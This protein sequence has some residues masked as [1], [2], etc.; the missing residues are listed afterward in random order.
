MESKRTPRL[1]PRARPRGFAVGVCAA[2]AA[3]G[4][5]ASE[6]VARRLRNDAVLFFGCAAGERRVARVDPV[7]GIPRG[8]SLGKI[9]GVEC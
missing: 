2:A 4:D 6:K 8:V 1:D 9:R 5:G 3:D 7:V